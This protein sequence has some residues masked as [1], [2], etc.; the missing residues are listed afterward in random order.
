MMAAGRFKRLAG[1]AV[2]VAVIF[3]CGGNATRTEA[4]TAAPERR[5]D[6]EYYG[7]FVTVETAD[8]DPA[9]DTRAAE[10]PPAPEPVAPAA[11]PAPV[12]R[13]KVVIYMAGEEP[14]SIK[15]VHK[16]IGS[17]LAKALSQSAAYTAVD[18]TDEVK[19]LIAKE[20][21]YQMSGAVSDDDIRRIGIQYGS[22]YVCVA[23]I[24]EIMGAYHLDARIVEAET[25]EVINVVSKPGAMKDVYQMVETTQSAAKEL[26]EKRNR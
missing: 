8:N 10:T 9:R 4:P 17:E 18:R 2:T 11:P 15:G 5:A 22:R 19:R 14:A 13:E 1:L 21:G 6:R 20:I 23:E 16:V 12:V 24:V 26:V 25:A 3:S 7:D